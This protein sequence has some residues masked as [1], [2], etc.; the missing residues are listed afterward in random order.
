MTDK[1]KQ[2][3]VATRNA[4]LMLCISWGYPVIDTDVVTEKGICVYSADVTVTTT[5]VDRATGEATIQTHTYETSKYV[6]IRKDD[7]NAH[8]VVCHT[9]DLVRYANYFGD[10]I[11]DD[12]FWNLLKQHAK[13]EPANQKDSTNA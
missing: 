4:E 11:T 8:L 5:S 9:Y 12:S 13:L 7:G 6:G 2:R 3:W 10:R 1:P